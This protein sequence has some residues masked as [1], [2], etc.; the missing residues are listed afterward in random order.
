M[1]K[2]V[3]LAQGIALGAGVMYLLDPDRGGRRRALVRDKMIRG[4]HVTNDAMG[5]LGRDLRNRSVG[6]ASEARNLFDRSK[7]DDTVLE[8]RIHTQ[9]GRLVSHPGAIDVT[10]RDGEVQLHGPVL[11]SEVARLVRSIAGMRGVQR[12]DNQLEPKTREEAA[13]IPSLQGGSFRE[14][15]PDILQE[16]WSPTTR[17]LAGAAGGALAFFG[18]R[19]GHWAGITIG[20]IGA[21]LVARGL[22]NV[23]MSRLLGSGGTDGRQ[24]A[25]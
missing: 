23:E 19:R 10:V 11:A 6:I 21:G 5:K 4:L 9:L 1:S 14:P 16:N 18:A 2:A 24:E 15:Q 17:L 8:S 22:T 25:A 12:L 7:P 3:R 20:L 13:N